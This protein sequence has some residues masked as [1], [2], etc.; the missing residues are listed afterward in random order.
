MT[1]ICYDGLT[2]A[3]DRQCNSDGARRTITKIFRI[4]D[5][6]VGCCGSAARGVEMVEWVRRG[7]L[8]AEYPK[9]QNEDDWVNM[10]VIE[11]D[12]VLQYQRSPYPMVMQDSTYA[13]GSG[14][15]YAL[16]AMHCGRSAAEAVMV[17]SVFDSSTGVGIDAIGPLS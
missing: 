14:R 1:T 11:G 9:F 7:R 16:A 15:D 2:L 10:V 8:A 5:L 17:A 3:A 12:H 4:G 13:C 6:R